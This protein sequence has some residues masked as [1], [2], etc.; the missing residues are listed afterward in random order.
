MQADDKAKIRLLFFFFKIEV[1][2]K[3]CTCVC[4]SR[5]I[6]LELLGDM[7]ELCRPRV[8]SHAYTLAA[9]ITRIY[10]FSKQ[11]LQQSRGYAPDLEP[12]ERVVVEATV[13]LAVKMLERLNKVV[14]PKTLVVDFLESLSEDCPD[15]RELIENVGS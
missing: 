14:Q 4:W 3:I 9:T 13:S 7:L 15:V 10:L 2:A 1:V 12:K 6:S 8:S 5:L 11:T